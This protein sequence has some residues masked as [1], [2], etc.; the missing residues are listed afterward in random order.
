MGERASRQLQEQPAAAGGGG[1]GGLGGVAGVGGLPDLLSRQPPPLTEEEAAALRQEDPWGQGQ[2]DEVGGRGGR[3]AQLV[4]PAPPHQKP[5]YLA[6]SREP[7]A[8]LSEAVAAAPRPPHP[9]GP[10]CL[11][12]EH[13]AR[14]RLL[15][16]MREGGCAQPNEARRTKGKGWAAVAPCCSTAVAAGAADSGPASQPPTTTT[17]NTHTNTHTHARTW[18]PQ[19]PA[20]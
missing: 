7:A 18:R 9:A 13:G 8:Q 12:T 4:C 3:G 11:Q 19:H 14:Q 2:G 1:G 20:S 5:P 10:A 16:M 15:E 6:V 17:T